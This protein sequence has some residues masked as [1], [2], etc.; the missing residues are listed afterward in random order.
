[1]VWESE[2]EHFERKYGTSLTDSEKLSAIRE[3]MP[4]EIYEG[5]SGVEEYFEDDVTTSGLL[6]GKNL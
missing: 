3:I 4:I 6:Q 5:R 1:M 2:V